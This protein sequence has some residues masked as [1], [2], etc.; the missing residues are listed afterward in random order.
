MAISVD[1]HA[2]TA[3]LQLESLYKERMC[4]VMRVAEIMRLSERHEEVQGYL[5]LIANINEAC[6]SLAGAAVRRSEVDSS[7]GGNVD[8][9]IAA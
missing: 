6:I 2:H 7:Q 4:Y 3:T 8:H 1:V 5:R 9:R